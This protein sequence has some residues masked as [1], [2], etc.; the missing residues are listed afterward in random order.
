M[1]PSGG[2][3]PPPSEGQKGGEVPPSFTA[4]FFRSFERRQVALH[5]DAGRAMV[6]EG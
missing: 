6:T 4:R 5:E 1:V 3:S 2:I